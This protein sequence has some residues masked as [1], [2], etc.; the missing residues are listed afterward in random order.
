MDGAEVREGEA[1][2]TIE[3]FDKAGEESR[4]IV[5]GESG[6]TVECEVG[7]ER[8][9]AVVCRGVTMRDEGAVL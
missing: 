5:E 4:W 1:G 6:R 7:G 9:G 3:R 2:E 8:G